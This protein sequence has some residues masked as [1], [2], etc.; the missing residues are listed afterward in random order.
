M[1]SIC[2]FA[3]NAIFCYALCFFSCACGHSQAGREPSKG[4]FPW[5]FEL[6]DT[7]TSYRRPCSAAE[8]AALPESVI[9]NVLENAN[10][11][12]VHAG[13]G[14]S[15][16]ISGKN[17]APDWIAVHTISFFP[18]EQTGKFII[19]LKERAGEAL[20]LL[21]GRSDVSAFLVFALKPLN[22]KENLD[23]IRLK[24]SVNA[25]D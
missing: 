15:F 16:E 13:V 3:H 25:L 5:D 22:E 8:L 23:Q 10:P 18:P 20:R 2:L 11:G 6:S 24:C 1:K 4:A 21:E 7:A 14:V 9:L 12:A 19:R 17:L